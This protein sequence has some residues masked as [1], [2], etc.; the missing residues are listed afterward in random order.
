MEAIDLM[1][2]VRAAAFTALTRVAND[3]GVDAEQRIQ[4]S[5]AILTFSG[6]ETGDDWMV[7]PDNGELDDAMLH[8]TG[9][10]DVTG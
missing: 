9:E 8:N 7:Q 1:Q 6:Q 10:T 2:S 4:A 3:P 5:I